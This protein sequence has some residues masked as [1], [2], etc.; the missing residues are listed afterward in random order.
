MRYAAILSTASWDS[1]SPLIMGATPVRAIAAPVDGGADVMVELTFDLRLPGA[2]PNFGRIMDLAEWDVVGGSVHLGTVFP[3]TRVTSALADWP[4]KP[5]T[6]A[7]TG[8][9]PTRRPASW[10]TR[11]TLLATGAVVDA[12]AFSRSRR[13]PIERPPVDHGFDRDSDSDSDHERAALTPDELIRAVLIPTATDSTRPSGGYA[14]GAAVSAVCSFALALDL[15]RRSVATGIGSPRH[16]PP[17]ARIAERF[18]AGT[19]DWSSLELPAGAA[20][21]FAELVGESAGLLGDWRDSA[22]CEY[23]RRALVLLASRALRRIRA[24]VAGDRIRLA[25]A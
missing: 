4:H 13:V 12:E 19:L 22:D 7:R 23:Q 10:D 8:P 5:T 15:D 16:V 2:V 9:D 11:P 25:R 20:Q 14:H 3:Y 24:A 6:A 17:T 18:L 21:R 1:Y